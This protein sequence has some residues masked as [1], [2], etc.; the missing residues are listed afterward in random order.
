MKQRATFVNALLQLHVVPQLRALLLDLV[1]RFVQE[2][3]RMLEVP[4]PP[5][6]RCVLQVHAQIVTNMHGRN[7]KLQ[8]CT[9]GS[10]CHKYAR[11]EAGGCHHTAPLSL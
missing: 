1:E 4:L 10:K 7:R 9:D 11:A 8:I 6:L 3:N 2:D 5:R